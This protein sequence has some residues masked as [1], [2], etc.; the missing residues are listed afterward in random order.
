MKTTALL[1]LS[2]A[3]LLAACMEPMTVAPPEQPI[4]HVTTLFSADDVLHAWNLTANAPGM[5]LCEGEIRNV[6]SE[7]MFDRYGRDVLAVAMGGSA[8][9][10]IL[11]VGDLR[12]AGTQT[13]AFPA[14]QRSGDQVTVRSLHGEVAEREFQLA[15]ATEELATAAVKPGHVYLVRIDTKQATGDSSLFAVLRVIE[16]STQARVTLRWRLL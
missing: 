8:R 11:D 14:F 12:L 3:T 4:E 15:P 7:L 1:S 13:S 2:L 10:R 5:A 16:H 9:G 6:G